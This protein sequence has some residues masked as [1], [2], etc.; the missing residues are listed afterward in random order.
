[1]NL[2]FIT[3]GYFLFALPS[4]ALDFKDKEIY[5]SD[6]IKILK[7]SCLMKNEFM[8]VKKLFDFR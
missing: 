7:Y 4:M 6:I 1:M 5:Y 3:V 8:I 2:Y